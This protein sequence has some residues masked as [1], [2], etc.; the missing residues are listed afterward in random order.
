MKIACLLKSIGMIGLRS[1]PLSGIGEGQRPML[2]EQ[3]P[4]PGGIFPNCEAMPGVCVYL[5]QRRTDK[6]L[7]RIRR[8]ARNNGRMRGNAGVDPTSDV[9]MIEGNLS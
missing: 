3:N 5:Y 7:P 9:T 6:P 1:R 4:V 8:P 2:D